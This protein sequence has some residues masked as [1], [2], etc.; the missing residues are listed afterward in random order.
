MDNGN[1]LGTR[2]HQPI[3][4]SQLI[5]SK[6]HKALTQKYACA[7]NS[8]HTKL[9]PNIT[10]LEIPSECLGMGSKNWCMHCVA[11]WTRHLKRP[12]N[13]NIIWMNESSAVLSIL[14]WMPV[15]AW[16]YGYPRSSDTEI[17][18]WHP[19]REG[20]TWCLNRSM[21]GSVILWSSLPCFFTFC[22]SAVPT[23]CSVFLL[24][25]NWLPWQFVILTLHWIHLHQS[26]SFIPRKPL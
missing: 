21:T 14:L 9:I 11:N 3:A 19:S 2:L 20:L 13:M 24:L 12:I 6:S 4:F 15:P 16:I 7:F 26:C 8:S 10:E 25:V 17:W 18:F 23:S 1:G 22:H 5:T